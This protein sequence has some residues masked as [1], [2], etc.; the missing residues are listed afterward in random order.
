MR[1]PKRPADTGSSPGL[2]RGF[3]T[4]ADLF[5]AVKRAVEE[6]VVPMFMDSDEEET[7]GLQPLV[8]PKLMLTV[9]EAAEMIGISKPKMLQLLHDG[10]IPFK[11]IGTKFLISHQALL[12]WA[13]EA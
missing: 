11:R 4:E 9:Q 5:D 7:S 3:F 12:D 13:N 1:L 6:V 2:A 8:E 10:E